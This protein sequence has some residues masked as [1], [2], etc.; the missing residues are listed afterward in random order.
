M[1]RRFLL[2]LMFLSI[3]LTACSSDSAQK[4]EDT[5]SNK[6]VVYATF[7][8]VYDLS[9]RII[10]DKMEIKTI[11]KGNQEPHDFELQTQDM[12]NISKADL[13]IYNGANME[14]FIPSLMDTVKDDSKFLDLSS[15]LSLLAKRD[16]L[17]KDDVRVNPHTWLSIKN[18]IV[19]LNE[20]YEKV[21]EIDPENKDYYKENLGKSV[22][23]FEAL[24]NKF[25]EELLK[26]KSDEKYFVVS[27]AAF[28]Y[29]AKDYG[30]KQVAVTGISPEEEPSAKQLKEIADFVE[31]HNISTIFFEGKATPKVAET[32]A[33]TTNTKTDTI[34][35]MESLTDEEAEMGYLKLMELN[36]EALVKSFN[37]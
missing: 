26:V 20:I 14:S 22:K 36:L 27:H 2:I 29:L 25:Q 28:N 9:K 33:K 35:T 19:E 32:L 21:S 7:F 23:E 30:L 6:K 15:N 16:E 10:G 1:K 17:S 37:E 3:F 31:K 12:V 8:P 18:A 13:I 24:D 34:Y 5:S 11:I 4:K